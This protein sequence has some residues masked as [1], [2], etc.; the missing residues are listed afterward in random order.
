MTIPDQG[1]HFSE[2]SYSD[3][4]DVKDVG[5]CTTRLFILLCERTM[6]TEYLGASIAAKELWFGTRNTN[7]LYFGTTII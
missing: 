3:K 4:M 1:S 5:L 6:D 2:V 7:V